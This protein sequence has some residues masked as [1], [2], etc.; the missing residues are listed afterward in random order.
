VTH[1][2]HR[3][4]LD[5]TLGYLLDDSTARFEMQSDGSWARIRGTSDAQHM[6]YEWVR[7]SQVK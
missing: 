3:A 2:K 6:L 7:N 1:P 4:W 5:R